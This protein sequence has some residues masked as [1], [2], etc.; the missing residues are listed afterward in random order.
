MS[1]AKQPSETR[2]T[3]AALDVARQR[4]GLSYMDLWIDY[5]ALG[6]YLDVDGLT[7]Y[8]H[9]HRPTNTTDHNTI[10][11]ALNEEFRPRARQPPPLPNPLTPLTPLTPPRP[12]AERTV[13]TTTPAPSRGRPSTTAPAA[14]VGFR[15]CRWST[16]TSGLRW[17]RWAM[18]IAA[19]AVGWVTGPLLWAL[20]VVFLILAVRNELLIRRG[21]RYLDEVGSVSPHSGRSRAPGVASARRDLR[22]RSTEA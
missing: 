14:R 8:L 7:S 5:F 18:T 13:A 20:A 22:A 11:H 4:L 17:L 2:M 1:S 12:V 9:G 15:L 21:Q 6:G 3:D 16:P 19:A 10:V